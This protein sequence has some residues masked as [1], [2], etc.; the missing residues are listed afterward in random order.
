MVSCRVNCRVY[1]LWRREVGGSR[2]TGADH[3]EGLKEDFLEEVASLLN[4]GR[5]QKPLWVFWKEV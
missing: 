2:R 3:T 1:I 5:I 4:D